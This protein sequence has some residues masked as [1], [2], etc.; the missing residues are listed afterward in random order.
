M[1]LLCVQTK[2]P[3]NIL[4]VAAVG[5]ILALVFGLM[6]EADVFSTHFGGWKMLSW[7]HLKCIGSHG[8]DN[9]LRVVIFIFCLDVRNR[10]SDV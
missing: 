6:W 1:W 8:R 5:S 2:V 9:W 10:F 7:S 4:N 3:L